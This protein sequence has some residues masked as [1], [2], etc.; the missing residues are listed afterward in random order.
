M[1]RWLLGPDE[2]EPMSR[3]RAAEAAIRNDMSDLNRAQQWSDDV[4]P[5][6]ERLRAVWRKA[7]RGGK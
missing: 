6:A 3:Q 2:M 7:E 1:L 5:D 4:R